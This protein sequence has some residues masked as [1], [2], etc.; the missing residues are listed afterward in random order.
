MRVGGTHTAC[1]S[2]GGSIN[3][4][5]AR[6][7]C[8]CLAFACQDS[9]VFN[10]APAFVPNVDKLNISNAYWSAG[11][12]LLLISISPPPPPRALGG[13]RRATHT[14]PH[15]HTHTLIIIRS[16]FGTCSGRRVLG[17]VCGEKKSELIDKCNCPG[18]WF[19]PV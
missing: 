16:G 15:I 7:L 18:I 8:M 1:V 11:V 3:I 12:G 2:V 6:V 13:I 10:C 9:G 5:G 14:C 19:V 17:R 4:V